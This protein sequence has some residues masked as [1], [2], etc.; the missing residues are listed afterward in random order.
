MARRAPAGPRLR[1]A[2]AALQLVQAR[3][4]GR[5]GLGAAGATLVGDRAI[6]ATVEHHAAL[7]A[8]LA[9]PVA[10]LQRGPGGGELAAFWAY[11]RESR[12]G[13]LQAQA[14]AP[15]MKAYASQVKDLTANRAIHVLEPV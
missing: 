15:H 1:P 8:D 12:P 2:A 14:V 13:E 5:W 3:S 4:A 10:C 7:Y 6:G 9:D 11:A